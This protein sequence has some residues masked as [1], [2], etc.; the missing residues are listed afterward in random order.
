MCQSKRKRLHVRQLARLEGAPKDDK[1]KRSM[2]E[3]IKRAGR[4]ALSDEG[5]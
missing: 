4:K 5:S 1:I 3:K 2:D